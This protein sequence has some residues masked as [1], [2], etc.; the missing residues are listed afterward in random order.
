MKCLLNMDSLTYDLTYRSQWMG[1]SEAIEFCLKGHIDYVDYLKTIPQ[2]HAYLDCDVEIIS[3]PRLRE[4]IPGSPEDVKFHMAQTG[5]PFDI[6][7][8]MLWSQ[9]LLSSGNISEKHKI[10]MDKLERLSLTIGI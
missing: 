10:M 2:I 4:L 7:G 8:I 1:M 3:F 6:N 5:D 9:R